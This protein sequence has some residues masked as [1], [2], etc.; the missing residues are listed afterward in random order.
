MKSRVFLLFFLLSISATAGDRWFVS[1]RD[2]NQ[3]QYAPEHPEAFLSE[4][5][6]ERRAR[7]HLPIRHQDIPVSPVYTAGLVRAGANI[8][9]CSRWLNGAVADVPDSAVLNRILD[10]PY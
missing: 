9:C 1:F 5:S 8:V 2:K 10:L 7:Q 3:S 4:R 6:I